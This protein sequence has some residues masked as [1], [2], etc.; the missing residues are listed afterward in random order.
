MCVDISEP[1]HGGRRV[2]RNRLGIGSPRVLQC[3]NVSRTRLLI[4][5]SKS[6]LVLL[7]SL[8]QCIGGIIHRTAQVVRVRCIEKAHKQNLYKY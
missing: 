2:P 8:N 6:L 7:L 4:F 5:P 3:S 1:C